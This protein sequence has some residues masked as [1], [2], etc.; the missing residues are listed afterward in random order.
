MVG[1]G[2]GQRGRGPERNARSVTGRFSRSWG[3]YPC[4]VDFHAEL[5]IE[6]SHFLVP[7][8]GPVGEDRCLPDPFVHRIV[9][10]PVER[11]IDMKGFKAIPMY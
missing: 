11:G 6:S 5:Q 9:H 7:V 2:H 10:V 8:V 1:R 3:R 4:V